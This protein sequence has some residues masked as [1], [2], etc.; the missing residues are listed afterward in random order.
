[1]SNT[2]KTYTLMISILLIIVLS[3]CIFVPPIINDRLLL[4]R[5]KKT[6]PKEGKIKKKSKKNKQKA[7]PLDS[8]DK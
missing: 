1:M 6:L 4:P 3:N 7:L 8:I 5:E 2:S